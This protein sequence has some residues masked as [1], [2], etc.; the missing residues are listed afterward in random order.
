MNKTFDAREFRNALGTFATGVTIITTRDAVGAPIGITASSFNSVSLDPPL[1]LFSLAKTSRSLAAF[2]QARHWAVHIL[3]AA[4]EDLCGRFA[5]SGADKFAGLELGQGYGD[6]PLL[7]GCAARMQ[8][9]TAFRHEGGDH[10][11]FVGEVL[12]FD[13]AEAPPLVFHAGRMRRLEQ[14]AA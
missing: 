3:G 8:C 1:V 14:L 2:A 5:R 11:I 7:S 13:R 10:L 12:A 6:A 4:Q 9:R